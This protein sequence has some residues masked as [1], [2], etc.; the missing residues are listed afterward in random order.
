MGLFTLSTPCAI[1]FF[2]CSGKWNTSQSFLKNCICVSHIIV[3]LLV[4]DFNS[5]QKQLIVLWPNL[6]TVFPLANRAICILHFIPSIK[7]ITIMKSYRFS[8][9]LN[10]TYC[11][12]ARLAWIHMMLLCV[13][14][15]YTTR[16]VRKKSYLQT[17]LFSVS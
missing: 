6:E 5:I 17:K 4:I 15:S 7:F 1:N 16:L 10:Y 9:M 13:M 3:I 11:G 12:Y 8:K 14:L 2:K